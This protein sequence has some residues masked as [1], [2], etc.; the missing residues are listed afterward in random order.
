MLILVGALSIFMKHILFYI[1]A[2]ISAITLYSCGDPDE[3]PVKGVGGVRSI[4][5]NGLVTFK[6]VQGAGTSTAVSTSLMD[7]MYSYGNGVLSV[8]GVGTM[9]I[10]VGGYTFITCNACDI[11]TDG[12]V[13]TDTLAMS[14]HGGSARVYDLTVSRYLQINAQNTG[15]Y[16]FSGTVPFFNTTCTNLASVEAY[17][18]A[19]DSTYVNTTCAIDT[20]V[21]ATQ[22]VNVFINSSG[23]VNYTGNPPVLRRSGAGTGKLVKK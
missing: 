13:A 2:L 3:H 22:V 6:L 20:E 19:T 14:I 16:R 12:P 17:N 9:T 7:N 18:L 8:N 11:K 5:A 21:N 10:A 23:N 15:K 4:S 1:L